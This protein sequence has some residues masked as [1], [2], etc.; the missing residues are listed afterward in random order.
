MGQADYKT[1][2]LREMKGTYEIVTVDFSSLQVIGRNVC[3]VNGLRTCCNN[4]PAHNFTMSDKGVV[5]DCGSLKRLE[6]DGV[7]MV[8]LKA[9]TTKAGATKGF[10]V[11]NTK[12]FH[13]YNVTKEMLITQQGK[14]K[15]P[16]LQN[17]II[18]DNMI[19]A[20]PGKRFER[21]IDTPQKK[22]EVQNH[23]SAM[24][25]SSKLRKPTKPVTQQGGITPE[26]KKMLKDAKDRGVFV[27]Y[28]AK[29]G[30][31]DDVMDYFCNTMYSEELAK[32][33]KPI[34][35][36]PNLRLG[37]VMA[38]VDCASMGADISKLCDGSSTQS[39]IE[40]KALEKADE[41]FESGRND[42]SVYNDNALLAKCRA[43]KERTYS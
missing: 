17:A 29:S 13:I 9:I 41:I 23:A 39:A 25:D 2:L 42:T 34:F 22:R 4:A 18:R 11:L 43:M 3:D 7:T 36:N 30:A 15:L 14:Q 12:N 27:E 21:I 38:L 26:R 1:I 33:C 24:T 16:L 5:E 40:L 37:Q 32:S 19:N 6:H 10:S 8:V 28:F 35:D 31:P 20:Y